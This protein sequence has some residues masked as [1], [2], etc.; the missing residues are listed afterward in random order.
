MNSIPEDLLPDD[1]V[2]PEDLLELGFVITKDDKIRYIDAPGQGPRY[3]I[4]RSDRINQVHIEALHK[5]IH[6]SII[7]RLLGM[8]MHFMEVPEGSKQQLP[9]MVSGNV[10]A[11]PRIVVFFGEIVEDLG[12][13]SY[14]DA[15]DDGIS[16]GSILGFAKGLLGENSLD[17]PN[18]LILANAG[19]TVWY[20]GNGGSAMTTDSLHGQHRASAV[21]RERSLGARNIIRG[22]IS[23]D[24]HV[25]NIFEQVLMRSNFR[26]DARIDVIGLSEGGHAAMAYLK[27]RWSFW[28]PHISSLSLIN[29]ETIVSTDANKASDPK[30]NNLFGWFMKYRCRGWTICDQPIGTRLRG[31]TLPHGC[32]TYSSGEGTKSSGMI[33]RGVGHILTWMNIMHYSPAA[34]ERFDVVKGQYNPNFAA[35]LGAM[36]YGDQAQLPS[37]KIEVHSLDV[38]KQIKDFLAGVNFTEEMT[39]FFNDK[40][41]FSDDSDNESDNDSQGSVVYADKDNGAPNTPPD[42]PDAPGGSGG[43]GVSGTL[44]MPVDMLPDASSGTSPGTSSDASGVRDV[45]ST[46]PGGPDVLS[47]FLADALSVPESPTYYDDVIVGKTGPF[48]LS[49]LQAIREED[50]GQE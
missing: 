20:N 3:K 4:N 30:E 29:P 36:T 11:A 17:S 21:H 8:G 14:R 10:T 22:N 9:I 18:A 32:N 42:T 46:I 35:E 19:Q 23:I 15:C 49:D 16:F 12:V 2:F 45:P 28:M 43:S 25:R 31:L 24:D 6:I 26:V 37:G 50:E 27:N 48:D 1:I 13:F 44:D 33:T 5:A 7:D 41:Y 47:D 34:I 40:S 38:M 39:T